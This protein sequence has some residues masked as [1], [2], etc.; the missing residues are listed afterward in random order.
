MRKVLFILLYIVVFSLLLTTDLPAS[1]ISGTKI[2]YNILKDVN[3]SEEFSGAKSVKLVIDKEGRYYLIGDYI[4]GITN[5]Y[6]L[7]DSLKSLILSKINITEIIKKKSINQEARI[8]FVI[9]EFIAGE[10]YSTLMM[11]TYDR[12]NIYNAY[13]GIITYP[14]M[15]AAGIILP[16]IYTSNNEITYGEFIQSANLSLNM[17]GVALAINYLITEEIEPLT[18]L[19]SSVA[20]NI[21]GYIFA[22]RKKYTGGQSLLY[23]EVLQKTSYISLS[24]SMVFQNSVNGRIV[25]GSYLGATAI[26][27]GAS[28]YLAEKFKDITT[29]DIMTMGGLSIVTSCVSSM[30]VA[31]SPTPIPIR[32]M[33]P[34]SYIMFTPGYYLGYKLIEKGHITLGDGII[35]NLGIYAGAL[36]GLAGD[37][38]IVVSDV[39]Y[40]R[41]FLTIAGTSL[42]TYIM[43]RWLEN[44]IEKNVDESKLDIHINPIPMVC[45]DN[46]GK[47]S[48]SMN[49]LFTIRF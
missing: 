21:G 19:L 23:W 46:K 29:G 31:C 6:L 27:I 24:A 13:L 8:P 9:Y 47:Y 20:G 16:T 5:I 40:N 11:I 32:T 26:G 28:Y 35:F 3:L 17:V 14:I 48:F 18:P 39:G 42:G 4:G 10:Y 7:N 33:L 15:T 41:P 2:G 34:I 22:E 30:I 12:Y 45:I 38:I 44:R 36:I 1:N 25:A 37:G 43:Y 49:N